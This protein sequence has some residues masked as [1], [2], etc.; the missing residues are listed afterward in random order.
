MV[1]LLQVTKTKGKNQKTTEEI[2][3]VKIFTLV[4]MHFM[5]NN[6]IKATRQHWDVNV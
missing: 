6:E 4:K 5:S 3:A 1:I 2:I